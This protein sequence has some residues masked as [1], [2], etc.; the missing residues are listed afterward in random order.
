MRSGRSSS[1]F[2]SSNGFPT[3]SDK[4]GYDSDAS[5][6]AP[7][8]RKHD[9]AHMGEKVAEI[10]TQ[11]NPSH[12]GCYVLLS[13]MYAADSRWTEAEKVRKKMRISRV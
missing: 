5:N 3:P 13:N 9:D 10:L 7:L 6:F 2:G 4:D 1:S 8:C 11:M 12:S